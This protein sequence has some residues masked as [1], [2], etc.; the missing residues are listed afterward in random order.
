MLGG[1][2]T[3]AQHIEL[4]GRNAERAKQFAGR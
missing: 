3:K 4:F 1:L 2:K